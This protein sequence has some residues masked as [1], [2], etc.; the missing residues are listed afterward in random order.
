MNSKDFN[1]AIARQF[2]KCYT[3][4]NIK[5]R[6]YNHTEDRFDTFKEAALLSSKSAEESAASYMTKHI[7]SIIDM[8]KRPW[9]YSDEMW[10]EK[11]TDAINYLLIIRAMIEER[12]E[13]R[14]KRKL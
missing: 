1:S 11:I 3:L 2:G 4:L 5:K 9:K 12:S 7:M 8:C 10:D 14:R 6:E 13:V